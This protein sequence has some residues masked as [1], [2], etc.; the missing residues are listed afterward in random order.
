MQRDVNEQSENMNYNK[1]HTVTTM[2]QIDRRKPC[3]QISL[4]MVELHTNSAVGFNAVNSE[5]L[6]CFLLYISTQ[7]NKHPSEKYLFLIFRTLQKK[8]VSEVL[9]PSWK[10]I[11]TH[12]GG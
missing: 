1:V 5:A 8:G 11:L 3:Y 4:F 2:N 7:L 12:F 10:L 6:L 9:L